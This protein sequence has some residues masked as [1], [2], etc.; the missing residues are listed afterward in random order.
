MIISEEKVGVFLLHK[1]ACDE[2]VLIKFKSSLV[3]V[4]DWLSRSF[5]SFSVL[6]KMHVR[7]V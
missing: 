3:T 1:G 2:C 4:C 5:K 6:S 7:F